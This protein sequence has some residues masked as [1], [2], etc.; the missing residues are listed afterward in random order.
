M[1]SKI[2]HRQI[3]CADFNRIK[4]YVHMINTEILKFSMPNERK[5][6]LNI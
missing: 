1:R 6:T 5:I 3:H 2:N 4:V